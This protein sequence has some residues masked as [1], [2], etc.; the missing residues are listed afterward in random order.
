MGELNSRV[1]AQLRVDV[2]EVCACTVRA[3]T[4][5]R[6]AMSLFGVFIRQSLANKLH[7]IDLCRPFFGRRTRGDRVTLLGDRR[8]RPIRLDLAHLCHVSGDARN[9]VAN[10]FVSSS[11]LTS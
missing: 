7:H 2:A 8:E 1:E 6:V 10:M 11:S 9:S 5:R 3:E 4:N